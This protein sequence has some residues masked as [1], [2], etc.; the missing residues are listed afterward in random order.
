MDALKDA[1]NMKTLD[2][3]MFTFAAGVFVSLTGTLVTVDIPLDARSVALWCGLFVSAFFSL[4]FGVRARM[5][6]TAANRTISAIK[7]AHKV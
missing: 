6:W 2:L 4:Y 7:S 1:G 3:A 5:A